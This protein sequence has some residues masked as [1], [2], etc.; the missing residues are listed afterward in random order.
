MWKRGSFSEFL[1]IEKLRLGVFSPSKPSWWGPF[2]QLPPISSLLSSS[3]KNR[4]N[5]LHLIYPATCSIAWNQRMPLKPFLFVKNSW[6]TLSINP[7]QIISL[8]PHVLI[9]LYRN[10]S[11]NSVSHAPK[12]KPEICSPGRTQVR[13]SQGICF[14]WGVF[15]WLESHSNTNSGPLKCVRT[16]NLLFGS[17]HTV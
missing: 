16:M 5:I 3:F 11:W 17:G 6:V 9:H 1:N 10:L 12:I 8:Q 7:L 14:I 15:Y 13:W 2:L 4:T